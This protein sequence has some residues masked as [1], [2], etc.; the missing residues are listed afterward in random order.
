VLQVGG[1]RQVARVSK[2]YRLEL[3]MAKLDGLRL[4]TFSNDGD[5]IFPPRVKA[6]RPLR[7]SLDTEFFYISTFHYFVAVFRRGFGF[8]NAGENPNHVATFRHQGCGIVRPF[9]DIEA[10]DLS[11]LFGTTQVYTPT[12]NAS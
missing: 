4:L 12:L 2:G 5:L 8:F 6:C 9:L 11:P 10:H 1:T 3:L 7:D